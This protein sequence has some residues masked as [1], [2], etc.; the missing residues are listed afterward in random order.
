MPHIENHKDYQTIKE[1]M[2]YIVEEYE[3]D[4]NKLSV[5][6]HSS[7][8]VETYGLLNEYPGYFAAAVPISGCDY[9]KINEESVKGVKVWGFGGSAEYDESYSD[10]TRTDVGQGAI[11]NVNYYGGEGYFTILNGGNAGFHCNTNTCTFNQNYM[12]PDGIEESVLEWLFRQE[13]S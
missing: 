4:T 13:K 12:S 5:A 7:G 11:R 6:G 3:C 1:L 10:A 8:G 2:D 9:T